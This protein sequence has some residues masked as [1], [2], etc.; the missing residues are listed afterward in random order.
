[1]RRGI[2]AAAVL[3][4]ALAVPALALGDKPTDQPDGCLVIQNGSGLVTISAKGGVFGRI[5]VGGRLTIEDLTP[6][7]PAPKVFNA[8]TVTQLSETKTQY[9]GTDMRFRFTSGG[10]FR[11][12]VNAIGINLSVVGRGTATLSTQYSQSG[13]Y[14]VDSGSLCSKGFQPMP[15]EPTHVQIGAQAAAPNDKP[16]GGNQGSGKGQGG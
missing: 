16:G 4:A 10:Q 6:G 14:S 2:I 11:I 1:M 15:A 9:V 3:G 12:V 13:R 5:M 7:G 8:Q